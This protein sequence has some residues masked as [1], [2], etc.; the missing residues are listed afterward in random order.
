MDLKHGRVVSLGQ[1]HELAVLTGRLCCVPTIALVVFPKSNR[2]AAAFAIIRLSI[3]ELLSNFA[4]LAIVVPLWGLWLVRQRGA[5]TGSVLPA[6]VVQVMALA[7]LTA[8]LLPVIS[9]TDDL[10]GGQLPAEVKRSVLQ[11]DRQLSSSA[12]AG[13]V[14][15]ALALLAL[16]IDSLLLR[17]IA[18]VVL[19]QDLDR[20]TRA[21]LRH[22]WSR[23]PP[24]VWV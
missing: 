12:P 7:M 3:V 14:P 18:I 23:P 4:W 8:I 20:Q 6:A 24:M 5:R 2:G 13:L 15:F 10:H 22:P 1:S 19:E 21:H 17:G 16:C 11:A 9:I